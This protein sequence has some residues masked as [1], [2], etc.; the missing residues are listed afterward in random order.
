MS[1]SDFLPPQQT[2]PTGSEEEFR[3][4]GFFQR[5]RDPLFLLNRRRT[6]LFVN[7]AWEVL[8]GVP[9]SAARGLV[10]RR[11]REPRLDS[12]EVLQHA[13]APT[14][15]AAAGQPTRV[16]R[17]IPGSPAGPRWWDV[18]FFPLNGP[19]GLLGILCRITPAV[20]ANS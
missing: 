19:H 6:I 5:C 1:P 14:A 12:P 7:R 2:G 15:E 18:T 16:R 3:W 10:C 20:L 4:Q 13:L 9:Q 8:T 11:R 17:L